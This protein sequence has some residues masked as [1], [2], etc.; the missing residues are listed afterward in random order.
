MSRIDYDLTTIRA[1]AF[2]V[3]GVLSPLTIPVDHDGRPLRMTNLRDGLAMK[4]ASDAGY[5]LVVI[6]GARAS[7]IERR[8]ADL[9]VTD[10]YMG[11]ANKAELLKQWMGENHISREQIAYAG[12]DL[13]DLQAMRMC[14]LRVAPLD[15]A[16]EIKQAANY[17][18][19][20]NG[21]EGVARDVIEQVLRATG[22]WNPQGSQT[23]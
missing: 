6:S 20:Y 1:F 16:V 7:G 17:I 10:I 18:S 22:K 11:V 14:G 4:L 3:D 12:D 9:G 13:P 5:K 19:P 15:A 2:D 21:G 8:L 23:S